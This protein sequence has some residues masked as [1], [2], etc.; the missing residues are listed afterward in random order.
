MEQRSAKTLYSRIFLEGDGALERNGPVRPGAGERQVALHH[1]R[2]LEVLPVHVLP[3]RGHLHGPVAA[4]GAVEADGDV[5]GLKVDL[6]GDDVVVVQAV[7]HLEDGGLLG[8]VHG[9]LGGGGVSVELGGHDDLAGLALHVHGGLDNYLQEEKQ[10]ERKGK[11]QRR[12]EGIVQQKFVLCVYL[13]WARLM[14]CRWARTRYYIVWHWC[15]IAGGGVG[16]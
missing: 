12:V 11:D 6:G 2:A 4:Q 10:E 13:R 8:V 3:L 5:A 7:A 14:K 16:G 9:E 1:P 15:A